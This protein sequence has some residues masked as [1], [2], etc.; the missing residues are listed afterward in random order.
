MAKHRLKWLYML[1]PV[2]VCLG[3]VGST[4]GARQF[5]AQD[6]ARAAY[7]YMEASS[8]KT[9]GEYGP[10]LYMMRRAHVLDT[11]DIDIAAAYAELSLM[12]G[13]HDSVEVLRLYGD[14]KRRFLA[15]T[16]DA[17]NGQAVIG[18]ARALNRPSDARDTYKALM[19]AL[20]GRSEF[21][22]E[23]AQARALDFNEGDS[24]AIDDAI[25]V[26]DDVEKRMGT[27]PVIV[28]TKIKILALS[29]GTVRAVKEVSRLAQV[30]HGEARLAYLAGQLFDAVGYTDSAKIYIDHAIAMDS[31]FGDAY[32]ARVNYLL[33]DGDSAAYVR[34]VEQ[35]LNSDNLEFDSK[36]DLLTDYL[37]ALYHDPGRRDDI[38]RLLEHMLEIHPGEAPL[39]NLYGAYLSTM[40]EPAAASEQFGYA[41][42]LAPDDEDYPRM[43]M[44]TSL[45]AG[46]TIKAIEAMTTAARRIHNP[47]LNISAAALLDLSG[48]TREALKVLDSY[49]TAPDD[50]PRALSVLYQTR[51]DILYKIAPLDSALAAYEK[52]I[53]LDPSNAGSLNNMAYFLADN[54]RPLDK[55]ETYAM[56]AVQ[57][58]PRNPTYIDTYAWV[59]YK[60]GDYKGARLRI[61]D[62]LAI[63]N[64]QR[65]NTAS[66]VVEVDSV[67][68]E[69]TIEFVDNEANPALTRNEAAVEAMEL[70]EAEDIV[71]DDED[72]LLWP[73]SKD[74]YDHAGDIYYMLGLHDEAIEFWKKA[75]LLEPDD[76]AIAKK[77]KTGS[78]PMK[79]K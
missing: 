79:K 15:N 9:Q 59:L 54:D 33:A 24:T 23:Y 39:H 78:L 43:R 45:Q 63:Y 51:G 73:E 32:L 74:I 36:L 68:F 67:S 76:K 1:L 69:E 49:E 55:A 65:A 48:D 53:T 30:I 20:P 31:T 77:V 7:Y 28:F 56:R 34:E 3:W 25:A 27:E 29:N 4:A 66:D 10:A 16:A 14:I 35:V 11:A 18:L 75:L 62:A 64:S 41:M 72:A 21:A 8:R 61:D 58:E 47:F 70:D 12:M 2:L 17:Y 40:G 42:D 71:E 19:E 52:S 46:D 44:H 6:P 5:Q 50:N 26:L 37:R 57:A 60:L 13:D 38:E 22:I